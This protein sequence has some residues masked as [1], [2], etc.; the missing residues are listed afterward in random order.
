[1]EDEQPSEVRKSLNIFYRFGQNGRNELNHFLYNNVPVEIEITLNNL[2]LILS[3]EIRREN[4]ADCTC[5]HGDRND[6]YIAQPV[7][8]VLSSRLS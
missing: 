7:P 6:V 2:N 5:T 1:M 4:Q 8:E 3:N